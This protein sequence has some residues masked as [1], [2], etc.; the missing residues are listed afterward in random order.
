VKKSTFIIAVLLCAVQVLR[1]QSFNI[2]ATYEGGIIFY[3]DPSGAWG[4]AAAKND[5]SPNYWPQADSICRN[6][7]MEK[8]GNWR[9]PTIE[10]L[11][12]LYAQRAL[13]GNFTTGNQE[14]WSA[15][16]GVDQFNRPIATTKNFAFG[17][18]GSEGGQLQLFNSLSIRPIRTFYVPLTHAGLEAACV[19]AVDQFVPGN[20]FVTYGSGIDIRNNSRRSS[21]TIG[22]ICVGLS[23]GDN[24][25]SMGFG[26]L[27]DYFVA[28][29]AP[30][31]MASQGE[32][33][34]RIQISWMPNPLGALP[35]DGYKLF[36]DGI[37]LGR[38]DNKVR[39]YNDFNVIAGRPYKYEVVGLNVY[40]D[41]TP[42]SAI[43]FQVPNGI[44]TGYVQTPNSR[45]V[46]DAMVTLTP[47][48]GFSARFATSD[49]AFADDS[50]GFLHQAP[51]WSLT[52]W[53]QVD[54][55]KSGAKLFEFEGA[56]WSL[57]PLD[58]AGLKGVVFRK[59]SD[60][61]LL[62]F[63]DSTKTDWHHIA[64]TQDSTQFRLYRDGILTG[65]VMGV[66]GSGDT[67]KINLNGEG[68]MWYGRL[69][70][71]RI[72]HR[73]LDELDFSE[74]MEGTASSL[75]P[76]LKY[77]WK[78]D[79]ELGTK[80]FDLIKRTP[81]Y[82]CGTAFDKSRPPVR[83][84]GKTDSDG[85]YRIESVNY[86][87]GTTFIATP[88]K[89]FYMHR[90][91]KFTRAESD[92]A[93]LP[94]I[95]LDDSTNLK[96]ATLELWANSAG[97]DGNQCLISKKWGSNEFRLMLTPNGVVNDLK[98]Y[99]NG[100]EHNFGTFGMGYQHIALTF[101]RSGSNLTVKAYK[102]GV[103]A[104]MN[105]F[106]GVTGNG[107][108]TSQTW[109]LG[110][111]LDG[112]NRTDYFGG[113]IDEVAMYDTIQS[114][115]S[116]LAHKT[117]GR[118]PQGRHLRAY[119]ALDEG[120]GNRLNNRGSQL[121]GAGTSYGTEWSAFAA[122]QKTE[123]HEFVPSTRQVTLNPSITSVDQ[124]D[125]T[126]RS[127]VA[128]SGYVRYANTD[129]FA[130]GVEILVNGTPYEPAVYTDSVGRFV[131]DLEPGA[132]VVLS[133]KF[134]DHQFLPAS[135][136]IINITSPIAGVLFND[137]TTRTVSGVVAGGNCKYS[138]I[139]NPG[140][141][142]GTVC[143]IKIRTLDGCYEKEQTILTEDGMYEF[144]DLP[145]APFTVAVTE[146]SD[147]TIYQYFQIA[148]GTQIDL[149]A[150][151]SVL[152]F[153]Y[154]ADPEI[155][156]ESGL[157]T[158]APC[159]QVVFEKGQLV[160]LSIRMVEDYYG[161]VC[162][163]DTAAVRILNGLS[164]AELDTTLGGLER[165]LV[166]KFVVGDPNPV[167]PHLQ[168]LQILATT[169][170]GN[171]VSLVKQAIV[172]GIRQ[173][174]NT[175]TTALPETP[176]LVLRDPPG[177]GSYAYWEK[178]QSVCN[179]T[180]LVAEFEENSEIG[181]A[182]S[183]GADFEIS[184]SFFGAG[185]NIPVETTVD[186][187]LAGVSTHKIINDTTFETCLTFNQRIATS[188]GD[189]IVGSGQNSDSL[190]VGSG[191]GGD[192]FV[193][194][195]LNIVF[196]FGDMVSFNDTICEAQVKSVLDVQPEGFKTTFKYSEYYIRNYV[197]RY[198]DSLILDPNAST[199]D[200]A[201]YELS[202]K[203]WGNILAK[204]DQQ[205]GKAKTDRNISFDAGTE[206][207][208]SVTWDSISTINADTSNGSGIHFTEEIGF[209]TGGLGGTVSLDVTRLS[210]SGK[211]TGKGT[212]SSLTTGFVLKDDDPGDAFS[213]DIGLDS[214]YKTPIFKTKIGQSSCPWEP[215]T[216]HR[217]GCLMSLR[218]GS[219]SVAVG[220]PANEPAVFKFTLGNTS[221]TNELRTYAFTAGPESNPDGA[222]IKLNG[223]VLD[224]PVYYAIPPNEPVPITVTLERGPEKYDY[225]DLEL[226]LYSECEDSRAGIIGAVP[227]EDTILYSAIYVSAHFIKPCSEVDI[228]FPQAGWVIHPDTSASTND[229][230]LPITLTGY[231]RTDEDLD[232]VRLQYR[233]T[234]GDG[235][236]INIGKTDNLQ[237]PDGSIARDSLRSGF[238]R[239]NWNTAGLK[240]GPYEIRALAVCTGDLKD[241][242]GI[243]HIIQGRIERDPPYLISLPQPSDGVY[244][245]GDEIS[246]TF[247]KNINC[248]K[249]FQA[250]APPL[251]LNNV[252]LF[253][254]TTNQLIDVAV[255]CFENKITLDP[256]FNNFNNKFFE[257]R[258]LR[259][260]L[261]GIKDLIGNIFEGTKPNNGIWEFFVDRNELAWLTDSVGMTKTEGEIKSVTANIHNRGGYPVPFSILGAPDWVRV[262]PNTGTLVPN[263]IRAIRFE[264][265][266][267]L[268]FGLWSDS[269]TLRTETGANPF[270]M[271]GD[272]NIPI[273]VRVVCAPPDWNLNAGIHPV[274]MNMVVAL[275][276]EGTLSTDEE[277][278]V[279]AYIND[280]LR[281][282]ANIRYYPS[283]NKYL[284]HLT[285]YGESAEVNDTISLQ[286]WDASACLRYDL[287]VDTFT[288]QPDNVLGTPVNPKVLYTNSLVLRDIPLNLGWNWISFNLQFPDPAINPALASLK[289]PANDMIK[290]QSFFSMYSGSWLGSLTTLENTTMYQFR[291]DQPDTIKMTGLTIDP[292]AVNI[293]L[294][295]GWN[296]IGYL[297]NYPLSVNDALASLSP[298][299]G[300]IIKG[301]YGFAQYIPPHGWIGNLN[302]LVP[303]QGY[304]I[305][306]TGAGTLTYPPKSLIGSEQVAARG[307]TETGT[308]YWNVDPTQFE[309]SM[310]LVGMY[311]NGEQNATTA[312]HEIGAFAG[313]ELRGAAK[314]LYVEPLDRYV[315]FLTVFSNG[316]GEQLRFK[317][318]N[319]ETGQV[320]DLVETMFF[321]PQQH[322][323]TIESPVPFT[324]Q[325]TSTDAGN[326]TINPFLLDVQPNPFA[327]GTLIR[328]NLV[329]DQEVQFSVTDL[330]G[331][332][333][334]RF[335]KLA[336]PGWN[337]LEWQPDLS[338]GVYFL[339][340]QTT[341]GVA[342]QKVVKE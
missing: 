268:A 112:A 151:D 124:V 248:D 249:V 199:A 325:T 213:V 259:A 215:G 319:S 230:L 144:A 269:I 94:N 157:D 32:L 91:L 189:L 207:E 231:D 270:F 115:D 204:N 234:G 69:D 180:V 38:F 305:K 184:L 326:G 71:L 316:S 145:P 285:I 210:T 339:R 113:L 9:L 107:S 104:G 198:L 84:S 197:M 168:T 128:V 44:V 342:V 21:L 108:D 227:D 42:G 106:S 312:S 260:E 208:S 36:R 185:T 134:E 155:I 23:Q 137:L 25:G 287:S 263:E 335:R 153:I 251:V 297:P 243:S 228:S 220:V 303:P 29:A 140:T 311:A 13:V 40:G 167:A 57:T 30:V 78:M 122:L 233:A 336:R 177:D 202:K 308:A 82:F 131:L 309:N 245:L 190:Y 165:T 17:F 12:L 318:H 19:P 33:L 121:T 20:S 330:Q 15:T 8:K 253:D 58:S 252:G 254:A 24:N 16:Q 292:T 41:G 235:A 258:I 102:N 206:Y 170:A 47:M 195:G 105:T 203:N 212:Q 244:Q 97:P 321:A 276:I 138:I 166:Y 125:F 123:P 222:V 61:V 66:A 68:S 83:T 67:K 135:W 52:A 196:G 186:Y 221:A 53:V 130:S 28:P 211:T 93:T 6:L 173:K 72:Y 126:D 3:M 99:L 216:A 37:F 331:R 43:G 301:Q 77:Y 274:T 302:Y 162:Y 320:R 80:S 238:T 271:G 132:T 87:T 290:G 187:S 282:R 63:P 114:L 110:A 240:D 226:V 291:A 65:I 51:R 179:S 159:S 79:E 229:D 247:N 300:D 98:C 273:G 255:T 54:S 10:E 174:E 133:P 46:V 265:D 100:T 225:D 158:I 120:A 194:G 307:E 218:D 295:S 90:A 2:G 209:T 49:I 323:G 201:K 256:T 18:N 188:D 88:S 286:I 298:A 161:Q 27:S 22:D 111:R 139:E 341:E 241:N 246:F 74:V 143:K 294:S 95:G 4:L 56:S 150:Q 31:V 76:G 332:E 262:V 89:L 236:W 239:I 306:L 261:H 281:G 7:G 48:Q 147:P 275:N 272:E 183:L 14:Y 324:T 237:N 171:E 193:G 81:M 34:D 148:G 136:E 175:F 116:I 333:V 314:A 152:D 223:A 250:T 182:I 64:V 160:T 200:S 129:C 317:L 60:K 191:R 310:T 1:A 156:I 328:F 164:S 70:E 26:Y 149:A 217:E 127:T 338:A 242:P 119:F 280:E 337:A 334:Q 257:N 289:H 322:Q 146:H 296:W 11:R 101:E 327:D 279:A 92:Y 329:R 304:Q 109:L 277:D 86:G 59:G 299:S 55:A 214:F 313:A 142:Q 172:T 154:Y 118:D 288:F 176:W 103:A 267:T 340:L 45:P 85:Y 178:G 264:V 117:F 96:A 232:V 284:A 73:R 283:V 224:H 192:V 181:G 50:L 293:P 219:G 163:V 278:L 205:K 315:F 169:L 266:S 5:L 75:T 141:P 62:P 35:T 39:N